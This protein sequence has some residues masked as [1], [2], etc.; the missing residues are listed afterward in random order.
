MPSKLKY[1]QLKK[2]IVL[3]DEAKIENVIT[4]IH[5]LKLQFQAEFHNSNRSIPRQVRNHKKKV[6]D[7]SQAELNEEQK[8][9]LLWKA[10]IKVC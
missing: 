1:K 10:K 7:E 6:I 9:A 3:S 5:E 8:T 4:E 2:A